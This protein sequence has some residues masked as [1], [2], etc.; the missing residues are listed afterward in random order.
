MANGIFLVNTTVNQLSEMS[1]ADYL[2]EYELQKLI[3]DH[4]KLLGLCTSAESDE[5]S[6]LLLIKQEMG[7]PDNADS[8]NRWAIDHFYIDSSCIPTLVEVKRSK[9]VRIRREVVGQMLD[10]AANGV[11]YWTIDQIKEKFQQQWGVKAEAT[12]S[13]FL[14]EAEVDDLTEFWQRVEDNLK[15]RAIRL[16]FVADELPSELKRIIEFLNEEMKETEVLGLE[17]RHFTDGQL[18]VLAPTLIGKTSRAQAVKKVRSDYSYQ[19]LDNVVA[20]FL[21]IPN[22]THKVKG[23]TQK[24]R[25]IILDARITSRVHYEFLYSYRDDQITC[26]FHVEDHDLNKALKSA[27]N[28]FEGYRLGEQG[29]EI[30]AQQRRNRTYLLAVPKN[31]SPEHIAAVMMELINATQFRLTSEALSIATSAGE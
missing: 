9:D 15:K 6:P 27:M 3:A 17:L 22:Q 1:M 25:Q 12:L 5:P 31:K 13:A 20:K 21:E 30:S 19:E 28:E 24:F 26:Q 29:V 14:E 18:K 2:S 7:V 10:Y 4:P 16:I 23:R 8:G 11:V